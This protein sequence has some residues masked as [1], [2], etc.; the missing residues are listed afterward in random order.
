MKINLLFHFETLLVLQ[1]NPPNVTGIFFLRNFKEKV[2]LTAV[3]SWKVHT[4]M[5]NFF[6][7]FGEIV[8][9]CEAVLKKR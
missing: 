5:Y 7:P 2:F 4:L 6:C 8:E 1:N 9:N 3:W